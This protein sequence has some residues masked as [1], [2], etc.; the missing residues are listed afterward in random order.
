VW[1]TNLLGSTISVLDR[2][3][4]EPLSP[5]GGYNFDGKLGQMQGVIVAPN[6]DVWTVDNGK[7]PNRSL[8]RR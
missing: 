8:S 6:G 7:Q 3:T 4:G 5:D 2:R 1:V